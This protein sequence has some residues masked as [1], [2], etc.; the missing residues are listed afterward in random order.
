M[1]RVLVG[2]WVA[3]AVS[4]GV[5]SCGTGGGSIGIEEPT[6]TIFPEP[7][8]PASPYTVGWD[9]VRFDTRISPAALGQALLADVRLAE[10]LLERGAPVD[11]FLARTR[12]GRQL[13]AKAA[14]HLKLTLPEPDQSNGLFEPGPDQ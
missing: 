6:P 12:R 3:L 11:R 4:L 1:R 2:P 8:D 14:S 13:T 10:T 7:V 9:P 5:A